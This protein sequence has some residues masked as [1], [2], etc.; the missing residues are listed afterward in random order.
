MLAPV[1]TMS[2]GARIYSPGGELLAGGR[3]RRS[4]PGSSRTL[5]A[6][7][8]EGGASGYGGHDRRGRCSRSRRSAAARSRAPTSTPTRPSGATRSGAATWTA[9]SLTRGGLSEVPRSRSP[10]CRSSPAWRPAERLVALTEA[11]AGFPDA[12]RPH[13]EH[14]HRRRVGQRLRADDDARARLGRLASG[15]RPPAQQHARRDRPRPRAARAGRAHGEH[16]GPT[17]RLRRGRTARARGRRRRRDADRARRSSGCSRGSLDEGLA[18]QEAVDRPRFHPGRPCSST[19]SRA[20]TS[21]ASHALE[22]RGWPVRRWAAPAPLFRR[23]QRRDAGRRR[24]RSTPGRRRPSPA[25]DARADAGR[26]ARG[27]GCCRRDP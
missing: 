27:R 13:D 10:G 11:L 5:E 8:D 6:L 26:A 9:S 12:R 15:P 25:L 7:A 17:A 16:D 4:S 3:S 19:P 21:G 2:E 18:P 1:F 23:R 14:R 22:E 24:R 20:S